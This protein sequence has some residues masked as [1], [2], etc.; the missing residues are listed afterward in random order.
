MPGRIWRG[1]IELV[2]GGVVADLYAKQIYFGGSIVRLDRWESVVQVW[3]FA[4]LFIGLVISRGE[5]RP[6]P[7]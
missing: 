3:A 5:T 1:V 2:V 4:L 6:P 7:E